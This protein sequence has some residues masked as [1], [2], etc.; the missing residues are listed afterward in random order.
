MMVVEFHPQLEQSGLLSHT[1]G[2]GKSQ[3]AVILYCLAEENSRAESQAASVVASA[4]FIADWI[5][6]VS[7]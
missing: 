5:K 3:R 1:S 7:S 4:V 2:V 6:L